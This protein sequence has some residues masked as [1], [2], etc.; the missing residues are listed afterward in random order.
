MNP[1]ILLLF[2][3]SA[4]C[5]FWLVMNVYL[6]RRTST[7]A[8]M[9]WL[10]FALLLYLLADGCYATPGIAPEILVYS[11]MFTVG[12]APCLI[13]LIWMYFDKLI[14]RRRFQPAQFLWIIAPVSMLIA[15]IVFTEISEKAVI[16]KFLSELYTVGSSIVQDYKGTTLWHFY[17]WTRI[18][19]MI[20]IAVE[21]LSA[22]IYLLRYV[23]K[24]K[25][26]FGNLWRFFFKGEA[27]KITELQLYNLLVIGIYIAS[28]LIFLKSFLDTHAWFAILMAL[29]VSF[30]YGSLMFCSLFSEK[31]KIT[32]IQA[33]HV[34]FYNYNSAIKGPIIEIM[35]EELLDEAEQDALL[36]F[37]EKIGENLH[38][39]TM[40]PKEITAVKEQLFSTVAGSWDDSLVARFQMLMLN[41]Q[42]FLQPSLSLGD[43]AARLHTNKTYV[44]KMVNNTY[45][46]GFPELLNTLR[47]DYA[48]Q[49]L[50]NHRDAKQEEVAKACGFLSASSF[51]NIFKKITGVTPKVWLVG[52]DNNKRG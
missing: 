11:R 13:P 46:L 38:T 2:L 39:E 22:M 5:L 36:R 9:E 19:F 52:V 40:T 7:F 28:K 10:S 23:I 26:R 47:I 32:F 3:P 50:L 12:A 41:E 30:G 20:V 42:L 37:Q 18:V 21:F 1:L 6:A 51:N 14:H 43:V 25:V 24:E 35:M 44:S 8:V 27:I 4:V 16:A 15:G 17:I 49:Y 31:D 45:N 48:E 34:M 29:L 33:K